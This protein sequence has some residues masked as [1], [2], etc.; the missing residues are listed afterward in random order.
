MAAVTCWTIDLSRQLNSASRTDV[1][2]W[3]KLAEKRTF[4]RNEAFSFDTELTK[5]NTELVVILD[6]KVIPQPKALIAYSVFTRIQRRGLLHKICVLEEH[7]RQGFARRMLKFKI[8][9]LQSQNCEQIQLWVDE[10]RMPAR[11]LYAGLGFN[12][13]DR[14]EDYY[15][16]GRTG[17]RMVLLLND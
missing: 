13:V 15:T 4:P 1:I 5:R 3:V 2:T 6:E 14:M 8:E 10:M 9:K 17:I 7:R 12:D 16:L 11:V